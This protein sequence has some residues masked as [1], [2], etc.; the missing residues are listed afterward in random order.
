MNSIRVI[1]AL[2]CGLVLATPA[3]ADKPAYCAAYARDFA[4]ARTK[5][6]PMWQH[7]YDIAL[8][9]CMTVPKP[10][11]ARIPDDAK[12]VVESPKKVVKVK[13]E[14]VAAPAPEPAPE[15]A[16]KPE[17]S[18]KLEPG[19]AEWNTYCTNKYSSF[20][21]KTGKYTSKTGV[22]RRCLVN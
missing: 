4:D 22:Q 7:K 8:Q 15:P 17:K 9:A 18:A 20:N 16:S 6:K 19:S 3:M 11:V 5:D 12:K 2:S 21:V 13:K 14:E 1:F 10:L